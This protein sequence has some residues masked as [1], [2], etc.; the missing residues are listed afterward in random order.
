[1]GLPEPGLGIWM[2]GKMLLKGEYAK[3]EALNDRNHR[4]TV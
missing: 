1:M 2:Y 4:P 3:A